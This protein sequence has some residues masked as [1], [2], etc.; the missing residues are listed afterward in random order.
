MSPLILSTSI[1]LKGETH[2]HQFDDVL[3]TISVCGKRLQKWVE[4]LEH[5][6]P[7]YQHNIPEL[8]SMDIGKFGSGGALTSD[9][10]NGSRK[11]HCLIAE[12]VHEAAE[13]LRKD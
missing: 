2:Q 6:H 3:P 11:M 13:A 12:K 5:S 7:L 1:I 10:C 9:T 8:S 4:V